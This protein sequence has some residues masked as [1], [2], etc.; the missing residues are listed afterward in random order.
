[1]KG[2][3]IRFGLRIWGLAS[4][5]GLAF[6]IEQ[7]FDPRAGQAMYMAFL[8]LVVWVG[9]NYLRCGVRRGFYGGTAMALFIGII[10][11]YGLGVLNDRAMIRGG[12]ELWTSCFEDYMNRSNPG[13][14]YGDTDAVY[15]H[16]QDTS[17]EY[18]RALVTVE[19]NH[20]DGT[21]IVYGSIRQT[22][23]GGGWRDPTFR[24]Y[25]LDS[26][27]DVVTGGESVIRWPRVALN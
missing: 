24:I 12:Q 27:G 14:S 7:R 20:H 25:P 23:E 5:L 3:L 22:E 11:V 4:F 16:T 15:E 19:V 1:M 13:W 6:I 26:N 8:P 21:F 9:S 17:G 18:Q 2:H 10:S